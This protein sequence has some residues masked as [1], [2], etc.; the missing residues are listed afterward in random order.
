MNNNL[1][2]S[3]A[4]SD[5]IKEEFNNTENIPIWMEKL[6]IQGPIGKS[7]YLILLFFR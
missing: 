2:S 3:P 4:K 1:D 5:I 7:L 6:K